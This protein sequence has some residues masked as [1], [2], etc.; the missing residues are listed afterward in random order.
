MTDQLPSTIERSSRDDCVPTSDVVPPK[1]K[2]KL[3]YL[4]ICLLGVG[5]LSAWN[6]IITALDFFAHYVGSRFGF[7]VGIFFNAGALP[8]M[9]LMVFCGDKM[10]LGP[11]IYIS[12]LILI[13]V[14]VASPFVALFGRTPEL[15]DLAFWLTNSLVFC[16]G[17]SSG[18]LM[19][20][21]FS[22]A[23][24]FPPSEM[25]AVMLG[26]GIC[27]LLVAIIRIITKA[28]L[29]EEGL[30]ESTV[31]YFSIAGLINL[32][33]MVGYALLYKISYAKY[34]LNRTRIVA[35]TIND[36]LE[37]ETKPLAEGETDETTP[38]AAYFLKEKKATC[39]VGLFPCC[40][41]MLAKTS[42]RWMAAL[43]VYPISI[44]LNFFVT[45]AIY[46]GLVCAIKPISPALASEGWMPVLLITTFALSDLVG[47]YG[48]SLFILYRRDWIVLA[49]TV[50]RVVF[51]IL[52][53][54]S[55]NP[56]WIQSDVITFL[57]VFLMGLTNG[58][59]S[60]VCMTV[61]SG[62]VADPSSKKKAGAF[63]S[64]MLN[65][66]IVLGAFTAMGFSG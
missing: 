33:C 3:V 12:F 39:Y 10:K 38:D 17:L 22:L 52:T 45:L 30:E 34:F 41:R 54:V 63:M 57:N 56:L 55:V 49:V 37:V 27:G 25:A 8:M 11:R 9:L 53:I 40:R 46:P 65:L 5:S 2:G 24:I 50:V 23:A 29:G 6:S 13:A 44:T 36:D 4:I 7:F 31:I 32:L 43:S 51:V 28:A 26:Q 18:I 20:T 64:F 59:N 62:V 47:R 19:S 14:L 60:T 1:D 58:Y 48:P 66:G 16:A 35:P 61:A 21:V 15:Q 42:Q